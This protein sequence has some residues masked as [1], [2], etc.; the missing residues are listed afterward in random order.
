VEA[1]VEVIATVVTAEAAEAAEADVTIG[2]LFR[3]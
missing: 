1:E 3:I 2:R